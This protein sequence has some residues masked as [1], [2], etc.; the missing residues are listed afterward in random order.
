MCV[1]DDDDGVDGEG[2]S[3]RQSHFS[4][5]CLSLSCMIPKV[6]AGLLRP[7]RVWARVLSVQFWVSPLVGS[8]RM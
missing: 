4:K 1:D 6:I 3:H 7:C 5:M 2:I 8:D